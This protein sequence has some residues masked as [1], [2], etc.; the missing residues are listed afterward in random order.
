MEEIIGSALLAVVVLSGVPLIAI[1][2]SAGA[3]AL[4]AGCFQVQEAS[5]MHLVRLGVFSLIV[6]LLGQAAYLEVE[7]LFEHAIDAIA[8]SGDI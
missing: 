7:A 1:A 2:G 4:V 6:M 3:A 8:H 5:L